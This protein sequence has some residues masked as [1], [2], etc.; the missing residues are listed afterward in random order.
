MKYMSIRAK[1]MVMGIVL[2]MM[3]AGILAALVAGGR[4]GR[5]CYWRFWPDLAA[6]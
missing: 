2:G 1:M 3:G 4:I 6:G 5:C